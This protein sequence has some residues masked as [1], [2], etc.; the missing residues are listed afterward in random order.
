MPLITPLLSFS[1]RVSKAQKDQCLH[2]K[3]AKQTKKSFIHFVALTFFIE[4]DRIPAYISLTTSF[5]FQNRSHCF[6]ADLKY[7]SFYLA[8]QQFK[9]LCMSETRLGKA[10]IYG[11]RIMKKFNLSN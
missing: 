9:T 4:I 3:Y 11:G 2:S 7:S 10:K 1:Y 8:N 6:R 5:R